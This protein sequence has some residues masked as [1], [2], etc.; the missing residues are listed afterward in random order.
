MHAFAQQ[1]VDTAAAVST[2]GYSVAC[3]SSA[4]TG[5]LADVATGLT[6]IKFAFAGLKDTD[7]GAGDAAYVTVDHGADGALDLYAWDD[8]G[9][10]AGVATTVY[11]LVVGIA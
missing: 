10:E 8:L 1:I 7:Q 11:W 3:G 4:V 6:E 9:A 5:T 2:S